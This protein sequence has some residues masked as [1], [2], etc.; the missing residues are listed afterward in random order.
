[1]NWPRAAAADGQRARVS[2]SNYF[3][4]YGADA[5][6][7]AR[8]WSPFICLFEKNWNRP[9]VEERKKSHH[10]CPNMQCHLI[11]VA[12]T[13]PTA[14][15]RTESSSSSERKWLTGE[16]KINELVCIA[17]TYESEIF[18]CIS[19]SVWLTRSK[20]FYQFSQ[21]RRHITPWIRDTNCN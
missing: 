11:C 15:G 5:L 2:L 10:I 8:I 17:S 20:T 1:M 19:A 7:F 13:E 14:D 6:K 3:A 12:P 18:R 16:L 4:S 9:E 21:H